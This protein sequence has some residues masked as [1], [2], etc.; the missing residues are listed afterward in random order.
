MKREWLLKVGD[1]AKAIT[2]IIPIIILG[3]DG[4]R[5]TNYLTILRFSLQQDILGESKPNYPG[6]I[7]DIRRVIFLIY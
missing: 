6:H 2:A 4:L 1:M 5:T 3:M 7:P